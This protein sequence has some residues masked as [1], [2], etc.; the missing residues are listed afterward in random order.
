LS[1]KGALLVAEYT[2]EYT[3]NV[4]YSGRYYPG[5]TSIRVEIFDLPVE[6]TSQQVQVML[7][8]GRIENLGDQKA[9][10]I[11]TTD[12]YTMNVFKGTFIVRVNVTTPPV[13][14]Q[15]LPVSGMRE[16]LLPDKYVTLNSDVVSQARQLASGARSIPEAVARFVEWIQ[17]NIAYD[18]KVGG[19]TRLTDAQV[20][21]LRTGVCDEFS[22]LFIA[23]CR[24]T[25]IPA[26]RVLG[27]GLNVTDPRDLL[28]KDIN[29]YFHSWAEVWIPDYGWLTVDPTWG[30]IGDAHRIVTSR[31]YDESSI[32]YEWRNA[33]PG[34]GVTSATYS[35]KL[36]NCWIIDYIDTPVKLSKEELEN[37]HRVKIENNSN[38]PL[39]CNVTFRMWD[40]ENDY[41]QPGSSQIIFLNP[42]T[43]RFFNLSRESTY[44]VYSVLGGS[45]LTLRALKF[46]SVSITGLFFIVD[47]VE[48][49]DSMTFRWSEGSSHNI[50]VPQ[51][52]EESEVKRHVFQ[53]WSDGESSSSRTITVRGPGSYSA[54]FKTQYLLKVESEHGVVWGSGWYDENT[55]ATVR[56]YNSEEPAEFPYAYVFKGWTGDAYGES[57]EIQIVMNSPKVLIARWEKTLSNEFYVTLVVIIVASISLISFLIKRARSRPRL[58]PPPPP[59]PPSPPPRLS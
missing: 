44:W 4:A 6:T 18:M 39:L 57:L 58:P 22:T 50:S 32:S 23:F 54:Y 12:I 25:G 48:Y 27:Y 3:I 38:M 5:R 51:V 42:D 52:L 1:G 55:I 53:G 43:Y 8:H 16:Y 13:P 21:R 26:R 41:W 45:S 17:K 20:L 9:W 47:G 29:G 35:V 7:Q 31:K 46:Y 24:A 11:E 10:V 15:T 28:Y 49:R 36:T 37:V 34:S 2:L 59:P 14:N 40:E 30:D 19:R 33:P 56:L